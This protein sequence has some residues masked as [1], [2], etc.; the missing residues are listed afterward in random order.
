MALLIGKARGR[1]GRYYDPVLDQGRKAPE[2]DFNVLSRQ[3]NRV[4]AFWK[5]MVLPFRWLYR[6]YVGKAAGDLAA[7]VAYHAL[8]AMLPMF[9]L[10]ISV[11]G[12]FLRN[13]QQVLDGALKIIN[14]VFPAGSVASDAFQQAVDARQNSGWLGL[15][16]VVGFA[17]AG[18]GFVSS[19][20]RNLNR[21]YGV[22]SSGY[23]SEKRRGFVVILFFAFSFII[24]S[25]LPIVTTFFVNQDLPEA[26]QR[27]ILAST[28]AQLIAYGISYVSAFVLF[29]VIYRILPNAGQRFWD[30]LPGTLIASALFL[31]MT[32]VFPIYIRIIG[33]VGRYGQV[34]GFITL[35]VASLYFLAH[36]MLFGGFVNWN[37]QRWLR[38]RARARQAQREAKERAKRER[39][40]AKQEAGGSR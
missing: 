3:L 33:G 7:S 38:Q 14:D 20:A 4:P 8:V 11:A 15:A 23:F 36:V 17:W 25:I 18:T 39:L 2:I 27:F 22:R 35:I 6:G 31:V 19:L 30:V 24:S 29:L 5:R 13:D 9:F 40:L 21:I 37:T 34:L 1:F 16:S 28:S 12:Y 26:L 10:I 32:Q